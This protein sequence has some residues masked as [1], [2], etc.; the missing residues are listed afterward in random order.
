MG[1]IEINNKSYDIDDQGFLEDFFQWDEQF[2]SF[3]APRYSL[4]A[5]LTQRHWD[6]LY[7]IRKYYTE[8][9]CCP[10]VYRTC[11]QN[12]IRLNDLRQLFP[13]GYLR[14]ACRLA[15]ITYKQAVHSGTGR[16]MP[17]SSAEASP[18]RPPKTYVVDAQGFLVDPDNWDEQFSIHKALELK[19]PGTLTND[20]WRVIYFLRDH[21]IGRNKVPLVYDTCDAFNMDIED[22][23]NLFPDGYHRGAVKISGL[24]AL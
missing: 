3:M 4:P 20:H 16:S 5:S 11:R 23:E 21:Y 13:S 18:A 15:G 2:A 7:F 1:T 14:G 10:L 8:K 9:G 24:P 17:R 6:L 22:M 12:N 19:M